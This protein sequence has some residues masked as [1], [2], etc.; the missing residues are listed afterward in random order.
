MKLVAGKEENLK[1]EP[2]FFDHHPTLR[3]LN[4]A[5][6]ILGE[7]VLQATVVEPWPHCPA[8]NLWQG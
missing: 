3:V 1:K 2:L 5:P 6:L 4:S 7:T 8:G